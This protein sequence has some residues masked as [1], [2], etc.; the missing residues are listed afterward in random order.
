MAGGKKYGVYVKKGARGKVRARAA[1]NKINK[2]AGTKVAKVVS[3]RKN[4]DAVIGLKKPRNLSN[5]GADA[6][7]AGGRPDRISVSKPYAKQTSRGPNK[8]K[9]TTTIGATVNKNTVV[10][11][12][13]HGLG[14]DHRSKKASKA[15][16]FNT[17]SIPVVGSN[18]SGK[19]VAKVKKRAKKG[20]YGSKPKPT[21]SKSK[22]QR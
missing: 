10:H 22:Q 13:T 11:E 4:A 12:L 16:P 1:V 6:E 14:F 19:Q 21:S 3:Q 8:Y 15:K 17:M 20:N 18:L 5:K 7:M 2:E 9:K